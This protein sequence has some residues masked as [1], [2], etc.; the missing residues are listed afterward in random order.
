M[1]RLKPFFSNSRRQ[2]A[3]RAAPSAFGGEKADEKTDK[4]E[5]G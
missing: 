1:T 2:S 5:K 3:A 4:K